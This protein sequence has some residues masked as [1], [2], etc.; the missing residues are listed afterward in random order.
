MRA[1]FR[2]IAVEGGAVHALLAIRR[3]SLDGKTETHRRATRLILALEAWKLDH[4][5]L[6][7]SLEDL[8]GKYLDQLPVDPYTGGAFRYK[9]KGLPYG[10]EFGA[11]G[12]NPKEAELIAPGRPFVSCDSWFAR[13]GARANGNQRPPD[14]RAGAG[15]PN[16]ETWYNVCV[17]PIP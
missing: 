5:G 12:S 13:R 2:D 14:G 1:L 6:P 7:K 15:L 9:P 17:F 8:K 3:L 11:A 16:T 4:G 10:V